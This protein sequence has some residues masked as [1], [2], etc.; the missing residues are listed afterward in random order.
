MRE[1]SYAGRIKWV[2]EKRRVQVIVLSG[3]ARAVV[4]EIV[5]SH[6]SFRIMCE[7]VECH[8]V[9][10]A[11]AASGLIEKQSNGRL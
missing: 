2:V 4:D 10:E 7:D 9:V 11:S 8:G 6:D 5:E 3:A 1:R